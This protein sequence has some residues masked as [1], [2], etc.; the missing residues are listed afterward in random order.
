MVQRADADHAAANNHDAGM[1]FHRDLPTQLPKQCNQSPAKQDS[2]CD[3]PIWKCARPARK[4]GISVGNRQDGVANG[5]MVLSVPHA[6][7]PSEAPWNRRLCCASASTL[8]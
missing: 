1:S 7:C 6:V 2:N 8:F 3:S 5:I 4:R